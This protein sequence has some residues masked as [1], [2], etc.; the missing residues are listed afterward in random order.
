[1]ETPTKTIEVE[2][3]PINGPTVDWVSYGAVSPVKSQG[4]C[5]ATYAFSAVGAIEGV[6][7]IFYKTQQEYSVQ[8]VID[9][10]QQYGNNGCVNGRM[11]FTFT[12][13][14][15]KG[16]NTWAAYPYVGSQTTCRSASGLFKINGY[17]NITDCVALANALTVRP[18]SVAVDGNNFQFYKSG[19]FYNCATNLSL[20][21]L[22]VGMNDSS[23]NVK[24]S[25]GTTWGESGYIRLARGNTCGICQV[26]SYPT[27]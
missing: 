12:Y 11:D 3:T 9:C 14:K 5:T 18:I 4:S 17:A 20:A 27:V 22:L 10:S 25:W 1:M 24:L 21:A 7:V 16:I 26:A 13:V 8:Q 15:D 23:W 19:I 6:S 2:E